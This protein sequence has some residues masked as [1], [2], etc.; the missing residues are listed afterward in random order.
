LLIVLVPCTNIYQIES[1]FRSWRFHCPSIAQFKLV[2][3]SLKHQY[4]YC[5]DLFICSGDYGE[6]GT[7]E[8]LEIFPQ[9]NGSRSPDILAFETTPNKLLLNLRNLGTLS[10]ILKYTRKFIEFVGLFFRPCTLQPNGFNLQVLNG[11]LF[12]IKFQ[13]V[14]IIH[15]YCLVSYQISG[16]VMPDEIIKKETALFSHYCL[17]K[18]LESM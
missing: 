7:L 16:P 17:E 11:A 2:W 1:N 10:T 4:L 12:T 18:I 15:Q 14:V 13:V 5:I 6:S 3:S 8:T 9:E